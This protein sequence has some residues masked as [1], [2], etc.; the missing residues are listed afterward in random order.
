MGIGASV[1]LVAVGA[2]LTF[3]LNLKVSGVDL[4]TVGIILMVAGVVGLIVSLIV[5]SNMSGRRG[6]RIVT[7]ERVV[8]DDRL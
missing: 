7:E 4:S 6:D 2:V 1:F 8:R 5:S 3:A